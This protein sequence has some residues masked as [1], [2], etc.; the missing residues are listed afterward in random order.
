MKLK[1]FNMLPLSPRHYRIELEL[2]LTWEDTLFQFNLTSTNSS[3]T[4]GKFLND[5]IWLPDVYVMD[6]KSGKEGYKPVQKAIV[7]N[8]GK[9]IFVRR[10]SLEM[11]CPMDY[12]SFPFDKQTCEITFQPYAHP[13]T[14]MRLHWPIGKHREEV[15]DF[16]KFTTSEYILMD[17]HIGQRQMPIGLSGIFD[18]MVVTLNIKR[19]ANY[20]MLQHILPLNLNIILSMTTF[21]IDHKCVKARITIPLVVVLT[22][23]KQT[24]A[25]KATFPFQRTPVS[26]EYYLNF[27]I[28]FVFMVLLE[29]C[30]IGLYK[31]KKIKKSEA[32]DKE[33]TTTVIGPN[34]IDP[35]PDLRWRKH[36]SISVYLVNDPDDE[37]IEKIVHPLDKKSRYIYPITFIFYNALYFSL[38]ITN[39]GLAAF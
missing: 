8:E 36:S 15:V 7:S 6:E 32:K 1:F 10:L 39:Q 14:D 12:W 27:S 37:E 28:C 21:W 19:N 30:L 29:Y 38:L 3:L 22:L 17:Y 13:I 16:S 23:T 18:V 33:R 26:M 9:V 25:L 20:Y 4:L 2:L 34:Q 31:V 24:A 5:L 11:F 35:H